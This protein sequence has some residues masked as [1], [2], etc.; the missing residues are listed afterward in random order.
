MA[1][2]QR[3]PL[4][5][6]LLITFCVVDIIVPVI[7]FGALTNHVW[8]TI[9]AQTYLTSKALLVG[10]MMLVMLAAIVFMYV[11]T[12]RFTRE[13]KPAWRQVGNGVLNL[14]ILLVSSGRAWQF[15][16][17]QFATIELLAFTGGFGLTLLR[18]FSL[19]YRGLIFL[20]LGWA[21]AMGVMSYQLFSATF[22][23]QWSW[24]I[25]LLL[26]LWLITVVPAVRTRYV[27]VNSF[28]TD[29]YKNSTLNRSLTK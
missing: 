24:Q 18:H 15:G 2:T 16:L 5:T 6:A 19:K 23:W 9:A 10:P 21:V 1:T 13:V 7:G 8:P 26:P 28:F 22:F 14:I 27:L 20:L 4:N 25:V 29:F 3:T 12:E 11:T 17:F